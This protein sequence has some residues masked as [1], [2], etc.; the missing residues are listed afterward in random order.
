MQVI[1]NST[2]MVKKC[3]KNNSTPNKHHSG[4]NIVARSL[5]TYHH[6]ILRYFISIHVFNYLER[7]HTYGI[8]YMW[9]LTSCGTCIFS[10][11][12]LSDEKQTFQS[13]SNDEGRFQISQ[14]KAGQ[15]PS[16]DL[17]RYFLVAYTYFEAHVNLNK[18]NQ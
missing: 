18:K 9:K 12:I 1:I 17:K 13:A 14:L 4:F 7:P 8:Y 10:I 6:F 5:N 3:K 11:T 2:C 16:D 15:I